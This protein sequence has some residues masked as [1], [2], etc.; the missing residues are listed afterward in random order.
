MVN[1]FKEGHLAHGGQNHWDSKE[2]TPHLL[3][4]SN[5]RINFNYNGLTY[6]IR[7]VFIHEATL[8]I[9]YLQRNPHQIDCVCSNMLNVKTWFKS[10]VISFTF[11]VVW[12][13]IHSK[14][15]KFRVKNTRLLYCS[16]S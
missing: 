9:G 11:Q 6:W 5:K 13:K 12:M 16:I 2:V 10:W 15:K 3:N 4:V 14:L 1:K 7:I 8:G